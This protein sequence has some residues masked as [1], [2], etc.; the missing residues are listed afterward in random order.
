MKRAVIFIVLAIVA[1]ASS[2]AQSANNAQRIIGTWVDNGSGKTWVFNANGTV[3]GYDEDDDA[4]VYKF[5]AT[6]TK[7]AI[8]D[9]GD[10]DIFNISISSDGKILILVM[11]VL[12]SED[13]N[14]LKPAYYFTRK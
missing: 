8:I 3:S 11:D 13:E 4:F 7:L 5:G 9:S 2:A 10:L 12:Q 1:I 6:D 14:Y